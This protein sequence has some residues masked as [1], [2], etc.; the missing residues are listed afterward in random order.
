[1][2]DFAT[3]VALTDFDCIYAK[4]ILVMAESTRCANP[5]VC[6]KLSSATETK[7]AFAED[8]SSKFRLNYTLLV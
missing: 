8:N 5:N 3:T 4:Q 6:H 2:F 1:M 7:N